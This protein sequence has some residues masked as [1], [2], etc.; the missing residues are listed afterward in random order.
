MASPE[1]LVSALAD[2]ERLML[3][4]RICTAPDGLPVA[5]DRHTGKLAKRLISAGIVTVS[6]NR[7][8]AVPEAFRDS[9]ARPP[10][11]PLEALFNHGRLTAIPRPGKLRQALLSKLAER[12]EPGRVYTEPE[13][14]EKLAAIHD[15]HAALRRYLVDEGLLQRSNDGRAYGRP[16]EARPDAETDGERA[17]A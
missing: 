13:V 11:D 5:D 6:E 3:F 15:D 9:L 12:F 16:A 17:P 7:Y 10:S 2:P 1:A 4:A 14:R 8:R